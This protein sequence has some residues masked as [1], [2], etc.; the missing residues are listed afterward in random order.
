MIRAARDV[1]ACRAQ[2]PFPLGRRR[3]APR[4]TGAA[5]CRRGPERLFS[6]HR[7]GSAGAS[8]RT[9]RR[10][11]YRCPCQL[12]EGLARVLPQALIAGKPV[13]SYDVD[14]A[15]EVV[16]PGET[17]F[18]VPPRDIPALSCSAESSGRRPA[19]A[20]SIRPGGPPTLHRQI[21]TRADDGPTE[22]GI[23]A[24]SALPN[25]AGLVTLKLGV[26]RNAIRC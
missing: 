13:V 4:P 7:P 2:R 12:R 19:F 16:I 21:P 3:R 14:G 17:G 10:Q 1:V 25:G 8:S 22:G 24:G 11:R 23:R 26:L 20:G 9:A 5:D 6:V 15:R 18:L